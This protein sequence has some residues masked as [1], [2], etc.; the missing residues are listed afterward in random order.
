[1]AIRLNFLFVVEWL[2]TMSG[3]SAE[4]SACVI[5]SLF[6]SYLKIMNNVGL[7]QPFTS[8]TVF[9]EPIICRN[10]PRLVPGHR[11]VILCWPLFDYFVVYVKG[12]WLK[13]VGQGQYA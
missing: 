1:M 4:T 2:L 6:F 9:R 13:Q 3:L 8:G 10:V 12:L 11:K 5:H 7:S